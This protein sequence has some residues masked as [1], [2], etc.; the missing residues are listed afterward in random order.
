MNFDKANRTT[1]GVSVSIVTATVAATLLLAS[2]AAPAST[3]RTTSIENV[4]KDSFDA[5]AEYRHPGLSDWTR[6]KA[7]V[8][9]LLRALASENP[10]W[11][12]VNANAEAIGFEIARIEHKGGRFVVLRE[13]A[14]RNRGAGVYIFREPTSD[15]TSASER[16]GK[17]ALIVQAPHAIYDRH[18]GSISRYLFEDADGFALLANTAPR[19]A[20]T[21]AKRLSDLAHS[22]GAFYEAA[23]E[24]LCDTFEKALVVQIHGFDRE[25]RDTDRKDFDVIISDGTRNASRNSRIS[26][27]AK[28][29]RRVFGNSKVAV[30]GDDVDELGATTNTQGRYINERSD[31]LFLHVELSASVREALTENAALRRK[32]VEAFR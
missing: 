9:L 22:P 8:T 32:F 3:R 11:D 14:K 15:S 7:T 29:L 6:M 27:T 5:D 1:L 20:D 19:Y 2:R 13:R 12:A 18:T 26:E 16:K 4:M 25:K 10:S 21:S 28:R 17:S 24:A 31:D 30:F 23:H